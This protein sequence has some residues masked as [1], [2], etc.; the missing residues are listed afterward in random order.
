[1]IIRGINCSTGDWIDYSYQ[2][3][4][5]QV[6]WNSYQLLDKNQVVMDIVLTR[7]MY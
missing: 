1:M 4:E 5:P 6:E 3:S 2:T 7:T